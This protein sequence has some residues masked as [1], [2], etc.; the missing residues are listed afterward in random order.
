M[1]GTK[2]TGIMLIVLLVAGGIG[3]WYYTDTQNRISELVN[4]NTVLSV[5]VAEGEATINSLEDNIIQI[6]KEIRQV[7]EEFAKV[8]E[9][10]ESLRKKLDKHDLGK[11]ARTKTK[12]IEKII[13]K[14]SN[15]AG[16]CF[17]ILSGSELTE[18][19]QNA[20]SGKTF[21]SECPWLFNPN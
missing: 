5:T 6:N 2:L 20:K 9:E 19:E 10:N 4:Q 8:R 17:E 13:N 18:E 1:F 3:Y 16:R 21:N 15:N 11:L 14:A 12:L 7:N